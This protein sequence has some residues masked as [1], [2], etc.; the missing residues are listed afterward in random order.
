MRPL[1]YAGLVC[2]LYLPL[3]LFTGQVL[4]TGQAEPLRWLSASPYLAAASAWIIGSARGKGAAGPATIRQAWPVLIA[5]LS[6]LSVFLFCGMAG[7]AWVPLHA[8]WL[9]LVNFLLL[10]LF[11]ILFG[12]RRSRLLLA[13]AIIVALLLPARLYL[14]PLEGKDDGGRAREELIIISALP[15]GPFSGGNVQ[16]VFNGAAAQEP[17]ANWLSRHFRLQFRD[18]FEG[19]GRERLLLAHPRALHPA[20]YA[21]I[22]AWVRAGGRAVVLADPLLAWTG[23]HPPGDPHQPPVTSLLDPLLTHWGLRLEPALDDGGRIFQRRLASGRLLATVTP[24]RFT[25]SGPGCV[26]EEQGLIARCRIG[27][28]RALLLADADLLHPAFW[29]GE[30]GN[31]ATLD[32]DRLSDNMPVLAGWL[33]VPDRALPPRT[34]WILSHPDIGYGL[35]AGLVPLLVAMIAGVAMG[36]LGKRP[37]KIGD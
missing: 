32:R 3:G 36:R 22:D 18:S 14:W 6:A 19:A 35:L 29:M 21:A 26:L 13:V 12:W 31:G 1:L 33:G 7:H 8:L 4:A 16:P 23:D 37:G 25:S 24:G 27:K 17:V 9:A 10:I 28:G 5:T 11:H 34:G 15:I 30:N 2:G 20:D